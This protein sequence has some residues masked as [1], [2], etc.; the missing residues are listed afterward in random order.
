MLHH[1][2]KWT[3]FFPMFD[4]SLS[5]AYYVTLGDLDRSTQNE[6]VSIVITASATIHPNFLIND[7]IWTGL[8]EI[9]NDIAL[10]KLSQPVTFTAYPHIRP[11]CLSQFALPSS[12]QTV[13][14]AG[15]GTTAY[16]GEF[17][18]SRILCSS[19]TSW[20][21]K[22]LN[23]KLTSGATS[24]RLLETTLTVM[25]DAFCSSSFAPIFNTNFFCAQRAGTTI[26]NVS[27]IVYYWEKFEETLVYAETPCVVI[28]RA[29]LEDLRCTELH[30]D[31]IRTLASI[32]TR[33]AVSPLTVLHLRKRRVSAHNTVMYGRTSSKHFIWLQFLFLYSSLREQL[34]WSVHKRRSVV[35]TSWILATPPQLV[36]MFVTVLLAI[37]SHQAVGANLHLSVE[38]LIRTRLSSISVTKG[39]S[40]YVCT[41]NLTLRWW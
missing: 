8:L 6:S 24:S 19:E 35:S 13:V 33:E 37:S 7:S 36:S 11:I 14:D 41:A 32:P 30:P 25:S 1:S 23:F 39:S 27:D 2:R 40:S 38:C 18:C 16:G 29:I 21:F 22:F 12:G 10:L 34:H 5:S 28:C 17:G 4:F 31:I 3:L 26:C 20:R 15:W 9:N